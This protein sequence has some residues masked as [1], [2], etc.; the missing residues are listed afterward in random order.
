M[1]RLIRSAWA[2]IDLDKIKYNIQQ[3]RNMVKDKEI[4][5]VIKADGYGHG[6]VDIAPVLLENG[7]SRLAVA[8]L[9]EA[10]ELRSKDIKAPIIILGYTPLECSEELI[11][12]DIEQTVYDLDYAK[13]LSKEAVK[14]GKKAKIHIAVDTGMGRIGFLPNEESINQV[15]EISKL[16]GIEIVGAFTHFASADESDKEY[17]KEQ[18]KK[19]KWFFDNLAER[20]VNIKLKHAANSAAIMDLPDT[21]LDAVRAGIILYGYY[22]S[23]EVN[24]EKLSIK[25]ALTLKTTVVHVKTLK[26]GSYVSYGRTFK[27]ERDTV[28][29]TLPIGYAD[30]YSRALSGKGKVII[31]GKYAK[32][33]GRVCMDQCMVDVTEIENVKVGDEVILL[34]EDGDLKFNADDMAEIMDTINYEVICMLKQRVPRVYRKNKKIVKINNYI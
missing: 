11:K 17:T 7:V 21:H 18:F 19:F 8:V 20:G 14:L 6:A 22:P 12:Y 29:A 13:S 34:G 31:N 10:I 3:I 16:E 24:K 30:G 33:I 4:I 28:V 25:P 9:S 5:A 1:Y 27:A 23:N 15:Y 2:E 26:A 32:I